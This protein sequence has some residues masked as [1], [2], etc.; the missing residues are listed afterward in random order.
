S[1]LMKKRFS[2]VLPIVIPLALWLVF[3]GALAPR[4][5]THIPYS[6]RAPMNAQRVVERPVQGDHLQLLY[7]FWLTKMKVS[8]KTPP[9][10]NV[11]EFILGDDSARREYDPGYIPFSLVYSGSA[12]VSPA[13]G[14]NLAQLAAL[15]TAYLFLFLLASRYSGS[16][17]IAHFAAAVAMCFPYQWI[18]LAG[19][20]PTGFGMAF[21]PG[22]ALGIDIAVRDGKTRGGVI[23]AL[24]LLFCW[25]SDLHC[26]AFAVMLAPAWV[27]CSGVVRCTHRLQRPADHRSAA[28]FWKNEIIKYIRS[29]WPLIISGVVVLGVAMWLSTFYAKTDAA[30]GRSLD[31]LARN[32]PSWR[33]FFGT[34]IRGADVNAFTGQF[35]VI[36]VLIVTLGLI[37][38]SVKTRDWRKYAGVILLCVGIVFVFCLALGTN[39]PFEGLP[40]R[41]MRKI[42]PPYKMIRQPLKV[43]CLLP[44]LLAPVLATVLQ[45]GK[46]NVSEKF[47][48]AVNG[49]HS[50]V[51]TFLSC[52][53]SALYVVLQAKM[54]MHLAV[55][56]I[57][58]G[59]EVY[60]QIAAEHEKP[61][62]LCLPIWPGDSAWS[63][64]YQLNTMLEGV[65]M[66]NGY[67]AVC[68]DDYLR[69]VYSVFEP[70]TQ[71]RVGVEQ[72][73]A[74]R[75]YGV[76]DILLYADA[77][78]DK[79]SP[80]PAGV[81]IDRLI[82]NPY[83]R[84]VENKGGGGRILRFKII[85]EADKTDEIDEPQK[86]EET[87][88]ISP[89][90]RWS[91][92]PGTDGAQGIN[93]TNAV[94]K[95]RS[96]VYITDDLAWH[97]R[98]YD[99]SSGLS[100][101]KHDDK[102]EDLSYRWRRFPV[103]ASSDWETISFNAAEECP[104]A[105]VLDIL[106]TLGNLPLGH[107]E[108]ELWPIQ[109]FSGG[110]QFVNDSVLGFSSVFKLG[111]DAADEILYGFGL[112]L[113]EGKWDVEITWA[114]ALESDVP[115]CESAG[116]FRVLSEGV[117]LAKNE[118]TR[119]AAS[120]RHYWN[121]VRV[122]SF[123][124]TN[125]APVTLRFKYG[126][127]NTVL[128]GNIVLRKQI[129]D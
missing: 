31:V 56:R 110:I 98:T 78:P 33:A 106:L 87:F 83:L 88:F 99:R 82:V 75:E 104:A 60:A 127:K 65:R 94:A 21:V 103:K 1:I 125:Q 46:P 71:G 50:K 25:T 108:I 102:P 123:E 63:S 74:L 14:W 101:N 61:N 97:V 113:D 117:E 118:V 11:Y 62:V 105:E 53:F 112:P 49:C 59:N 84:H 12:Y 121:T 8:G 58:A 40:L 42:A 128:F 20:S 24:A 4:F 85:G 54:E 111:E 18:T 6:A 122:C 90:R 92:I 57:P 116:T 41:I 68:T 13:F 55:C 44:T 124:T 69:D 28:T 70:I 5:A 66:V 34:V 86:P 80:F 129:A 15:L 96:P 39:G 32:S 91:S 29:L 7:H 115:M 93:P 2:A 73:A 72:L 23:A 47:K 77:F 107:D 81:T 109:L 48:H 35:V 27:L 67:S 10:S 126:G 36:F 95:S 37:I 16:R 79:V 52:V 89:A 19:G 45:M 120:H 30:G 114:E 100:E 76:T 119:N 3:F 22:V 26:L 17:L 43:F 38:K 64:L 51:E 9:F